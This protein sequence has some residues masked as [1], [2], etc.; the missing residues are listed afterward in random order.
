[1]FDERYQIFL[2]DTDESRRLH[3]KLRFEI[4]CIDRS[5]ENHSKSPEQEEVD[6]ADSHA[7]HFIHDESFFTATLL[8]DL[9]VLM[10][11]DLCHKPKNHAHCD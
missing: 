8:N 4:Y 7:L 6:E 2:A 3:F 5:F 11:K 9:R 1:M 10:N